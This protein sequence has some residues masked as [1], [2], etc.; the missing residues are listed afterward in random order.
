MGCG[1]KLGPRRS[2]EVGEVKMTG[3][4]FTLPTPGTAP[5]NA[6]FRVTMTGKEVLKKPIYGPASFI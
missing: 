6:L 3:V 2:G 1:R 4:Q 5:P